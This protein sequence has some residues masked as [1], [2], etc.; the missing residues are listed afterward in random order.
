MVTDITTI[1]KARTKNQ[2]LTI[3]E[4]PLIASGDANTV[5]VHFEFDPTWSAFTVK[6]ACFNKANTPQIVYKVMLSDDGYATVPH[7]VLDEAGDIFFGVKGYIPD[8]PEVIKTSL[9]TKY[10]IMLGVSPRSSAPPTPDEFAQMMQEVSRIKQEATDEMADMNATLQEY[11]ENEAARSDAETTRQTNEANRTEAEN[12]RELRD[13]SRAEAELIRASAENAR[14]S[15][16]Q[17]RVS[18]EAERVAAESSRAEEFAAWGSTI[19]GVGQYDSRIDKNYKLITN[20]AQGMTF[21]S[22]IDS[23]DSYTKTVPA[24]ALPYAEVLEVGGMTD[25]PP[26]QILTPIYS[27]G[28]AD[29]NN[30]HVSVPTTTL[31]IVVT[32]KARSSV[33]QRLQLN[34]N[35]SMWV[36]EFDVPADNEWHEYST[37][38][39][40]DHYAWGQGGWME[41]QPIEGDIYLYDSTYLP[42]MN[43]EAKGLTFSTEEL[44]AGDTLAHAKVT[45]IESKYGSNVHRMLIPAAVQ[46]LDGYGIGGVLERYYGGSVG[47]PLY[48]YISWESKKFVEP[49]RRVVFDGTEEWKETSNNYGKMYLTKLPEEGAYYQ[50]GCLAALDGECVEMPKQEMSYCI[51]GSDFMVRSDKSLADFIAFIAAKPVEVVYPRYTKVERD[52]SAIL[53]DDNLIKVTGG[54]TITAVNEH[55][56]NVNTTIKFQLKG[57]AE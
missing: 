43:A 29:A 15:N 38:I 57:A 40:K 18:T 30:T 11:G 1:I 48:N 45:A 31:P 17:T 12:S 22:Q 5:L 37:R 21:P 44:V 33:A 26:K 49:I 50:Y 41:G 42:P 2:L 8:H 23:S 53:P 34:M 14:N 51:N 39:E 6:Y 3:A 20:L 16:E 7:E 19:A 25:I 55:K 4:R 28:E 27:T 35:A 52:I 54:G 46:A 9:N 56:L 36:F 10:N 24:K 32:V 47:V 13:M